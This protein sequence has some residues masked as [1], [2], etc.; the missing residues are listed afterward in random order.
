MSSATFDTPAERRARGDAGA[1]PAVADD[2]D[3]EVVDASPDDGTGIVASSYGRR[4]GA[5]QHNALVASAARLNLNDRRAIETT[6]ARRQA[7]Q[8]EAWD[9]YDE[10]GEIGYTLGFL[11]N[12]MSKLRLYPAVRPDPD[13]SPVPVDH[14][15]AK[16]T[17]ETALLAVQTLA[18]LRSAQGGQSA[19]LREMS[20]NLEVTGECYLHGHEDKPEYDEDSQPGPTTPPAPPGPDG[21]EERDVNLEAVEDWQIR[22]V[23]ELTVIGDQFVLRRGP[24]AKVG[25]PIPESDLVV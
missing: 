3:M 7:W 20:L 15:D 24:G 2:D 5:N 1:G 4:D 19:I 6:R 14:E 21:A 22:S 12:L 18:R 8:S 9:Y 11:S 23:D 16:V 25:T 13:S 10:I 17:P